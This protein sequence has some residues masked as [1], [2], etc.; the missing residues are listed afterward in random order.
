M[1]AGFNIDYRRDGRAF[2]AKNNAGYEVDIN[3]E[4]FNII[5]IAV[6]PPEE[7]PDAPN[8]SVIPDTPNTPSTNVDDST[9]FKSALDSYEKF[10][11][12][13]IAFMDKYKDNPYDLAILGEYSKFL[14]QYSETMNKMSAID[15]S[16]LSADDLA[17]YFEVTGRIYAK[18]G[19]IAG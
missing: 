18:L 3:Y 5:Y 17:Y 14:E 12:E 11:D 1:K 8:T 10:F 6:T 7:T 16:S 2:T 15:T 4:G 9:D 19:D 13:Y